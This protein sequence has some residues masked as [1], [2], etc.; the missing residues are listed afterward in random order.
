M[1]EVGAVVRSVTV[2]VSDQPA[3]LSELGEEGGGR[4]GG[5]G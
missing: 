4:G 1:K 2:G 5:L 3:V